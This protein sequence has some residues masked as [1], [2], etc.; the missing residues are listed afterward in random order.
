MTHPYVCLQ[1]G[2]NLPARYRLSSLCL[3]EL[4]I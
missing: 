3:E 1:Q 4:Y 2:T